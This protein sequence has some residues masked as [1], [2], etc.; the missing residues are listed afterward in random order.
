[1]GGTGKTGGHKSPVRHMECLLA[2]LVRRL[3]SYFRNIEKHRKNYFQSTA[4]VQ[5]REF[6]VRGVMWEYHKNK[7]GLKLYQWYVHFSLGR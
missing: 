6:G 7:A 4:E 1:M 2:L 3:T 5:F